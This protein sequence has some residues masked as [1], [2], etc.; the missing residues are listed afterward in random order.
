MNK[1]KEKILTTFPDL[2]DQQKKAIFETE[3]PLL[4]IAGP[5]TGKTL[6]LV[7]RTAY[8]ILSEKA[9][10]SE[11]I[12]TTFTEKASFEL[13]DRISESARKLEIKASLHELKI[14]TIHSLC[15]FFISK[16]VAYTPLKKNYVILDD[17][18]QQ[19]FL[20]E[21]FEEIIGNKFI[22]KWKSKWERIKRIIPYLNKI[23]EEL[24][25]IEKLKSGNTFHKK[26][27]EAYLSYR[28]KLFENNKIDFPHL[29]KIFLDLLLN[30]EIYLKIKQKIKYIM[31]DE[32]QD[33]NYIQEKIALRLSHPDYNLCVVGD[34]DQSLY[35]FR[36]ATVR[37]IL[38][39]PK[40][41]D[42]CQIIKLEKN[43]RSHPKII[44]AYSNFI[45][46]VNWC[47]ENEIYYRY[48]DKKVIPAET[49]ES[50]EYPAIFCIWGADEKDEADRIANLIDFLKKNRT[51]KDYSDVAILLKSV[52]L[53]HSGHYINAFKKHNI[54][55]FC[56]RAK[57]YF[58]NEE[59][60][61]LLACYAV[62][63]GFYGK[64]L[65][66]YD[67]K[68][69]IEEGIQ[70]LGKYL[71]TPLKDYLR[72]K[73]E[74]ILLLNEGDTLDLTISDYFFQ[75]LAY[76][77]FSDFLKDENKA[78]NFSIFSQLL[79]A[80]QVYYHISI[81]TFKNKDVIKY[82]LF[83][84]FFNFLIK[85][86]MDEYEDP[87]NPIPKG[88][89]QLMT[90]HQSK[91]LEFPVVIVG[92]LHKIFQA[93]KQID[94]DLS[95]YYPRGKFEPE[96]RITEFDR[97]RH[98]YVA[99]SRAQKLLVLTTPKKPK[100][101]FVPIWEGLEQWPYVKKELLKAQ[102]FK[103]KPPFIPKKSYSLSSHINIYETCPLQYLFYREYKFQ[104]SRAGQILFGI[105]VHQTIEDIHRLVLDGKKKEIDEIK[106]E[107]LFEENY[108]SLLATG[109]RPLAKT[110]KESALKQVITYFRQ[111]QDLL[112]R[113]VETEV[114][115]S[116]EKEDYIIVGK[117]DL[118]L[119]KDDKLEILDFKTQPRPDYGDPLIEKYRKQLCHY[120]YIIRERYG[121]MPERLY[122]Y[123]T[124]EERRKDALMELN[125]NENLIDEAGLYFDNVVKKIRERKF[126]VKIKPD[127]NKV[128]KD[129]DFRF[130]CSRQ[131]IIKF[132]GGW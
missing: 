111:N 109:L 79:N 108:E 80:F 28:D 59:I 95:E 14:G 5:G 1:V 63:F 3:G 54:P 7:L 117:V 12:L 75:I 34:E 91:G 118:L 16:Y 39:F 93:Q 126:E 19:L 113:I 67:E 56:P 102:N 78:R 51:I 29:Q 128:C 105:L 120:A 45:N 24:I 77:P 27:A 122:I 84:S 18:T 61:L 112:E 33:T 17:L 42:D 52:R 35:R 101:Y 11:I 124:P 99:F 62:I 129:C 98:F 73:A 10:P 123:W 30:K 15:D 82:L 71:N 37:N 74:Q 32:Y 131:G 116:V 94:R 107:E 96:N 81:V 104:P 69:Y 103:S 70:H 50:P 121:K 55:Y 2:N 46:S 9:E 76:K 41:F 48:P 21:K 57:A 85:G 89:V 44:S 38:E 20:Y 119:G 66:K 60:K 114:D 132:K 40:H 43:Y 47:D 23:T 36:G 64:D 65:N 87:D 86:G 115:V 8:L 92:S 49:T 90:I 127:V 68:K 26:L 130:Y 88:F 100:E 13:R 110:P 22:E 72:R 97:T 6:V 31:I 106:I 53:N 4:I 25:D 83:N 125:Y 58:E